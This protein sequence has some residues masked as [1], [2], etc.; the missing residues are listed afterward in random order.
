[1]I[2]SNEM[3][4]GKGSSFGTFGELL[5]GV[6]TEGRDFLVTFPI[7]RYSHAF[8]TPDSHQ[9]GV[10]VEPDF[11]EKS[12]LLAEWIL[13]HYSFPVGGKLKIESEL[14]V[15]KGM[16]SSSADL[17][18]TAR[19]VES[20]MGIEV[21]LDL[22]QRLMRRIEPSDGV[23]YPGV[24]SYYHRNVSLCE[25]L[26]WLPGLTVVGLDEGGEVDTIQFNQIPKMFSKSEKMLYSQLLKSVTEALKRRD[27]ITVGQV[28]TQ[29]A[30]MNQKLKPKKNLQELI[31]LCDTVDGLGV[32][33]AHSG[34]CLGVLLDQ[35]RPDYDEQ[36]S[37]L[38]ERTQ[39]LLLAP[40]LFYSLNVSPSP[41]GKLAVY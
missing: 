32:I 24:V 33:V 38:M 20:C 29:S 31:S 3:L 34:T 27:L 39:K 8:F 35:S 22:L 36:L 5:Q 9:K 28:A 13:D 17:V 37:E 26:G 4:K 40:E 2:G 25:F 14:P 6:D 41:M 11:K 15:G 16:S 21:P 10:M 18:A 19:A 1:M 7:C 30:L 23:M 12:R